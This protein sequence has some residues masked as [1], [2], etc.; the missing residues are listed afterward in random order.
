[1]PYQKWME[2]PKK[3]D[4]EAYYQQFSRDKTVA[5]AVVDFIHSDFE[6]GDG[7]IA[8]DYLYTLFLNKTGLT[9]VTMGEFFGIMSKNR[10]VERSRIDDYPAYIGLKLVA[11]IKTFR[12]EE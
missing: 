2:K 9:D 7:I 10:R 6:Y 1:M 5:Q 4:T 11:Q 12:F 8:A 3:A